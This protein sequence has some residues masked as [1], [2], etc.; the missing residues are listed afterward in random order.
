MYAFRPLLVFF[1]SVFPSVAATF[2]TVVAHPQ[3]LADLVIDEARKR[4]YVVNTASNQVEVYA[5]NTNPPRQTNVIKTDSVPLAIAMSRSGNLLYVACYSASS[6]DV[7]DL[8]SSTFASRSITLA[9][10]PEGLAVGFNEKV[11]ISTIGTG[12]GQDILITFD[13]TVAASQALG[14]VVIAP[15]APSAPTLPPP[16]GA[17]GLAS[18]ARLQASQ[19]GKTIIGVHEQANNTRTVFVFDVNSSTVL[20]SRNI[21]VISPVVA[22]SPDATRFLSGPTLLETSSL[23]VLGQQSATNAPFVFPTGATFNNQTSQGGAVFAQ[24]ILGQVLITGYNIVPVESP[25]AATNTS[26]LLFNNPNNMLIELGI[27]IPETLS[28]KMAITSDSAT[29]YALSQ[30]GFMVLP[31]GTLPQTPIA[32]P[33]S[34]VVLLANDQCGVTAAQNSA[35]IPVRNIGGKTLT[36]SVQVLTSASTSPTVRV[37]SR[38][39]GG[40][41]TAQF[42]AA[43]A[44]TIGTAAPDQLLIQSSEAVNI[45]PNVRVYQNNRNSEARGTIVPL[46]IGATTTGLTDM[47]ADSARQRLY[48]ANP[49]LNRIEIFDM[50]KQQFL[51]PITVGQ[52]PLSMAF[53][54]DGNTLYVANSGS[55]SISIVDLTEQAVVGRVSLPPIPM[56]AAFAILTPTVLASS[57]HGPQVIMS[58]GTPWKIVGNTLTP[59]TLN[60]N[61]VGS[62]RSIPAPQTMAGTPDG[63]YVL[64]LAGNGSAYLYDASVDDFV[65]TRSVIPTPIQGYYG[66][67]AAGLSGQYYLVNGQVLNAALTPI[68]SGA[69][70][71]GPTGGGG[72]PSPTGPTV[73]PRPV[74][75][76]AA[77]GTQSFAR[78]STPVRAS[79]SV[80]PSDAGLV[81]IVDASTERTI[82]SANALEGPLTA[83][84]GTARVNT[85]GRIMALDA[86]GAT[87]YV[88]TES[89]LSIIPISA[90]TP[91]A[92]QLTGSAVVNAANFTSPVAPIGLISIFGKNLAATAAASSTPLP[93]V[94]GGTCVTVNNAPIPLLATTAS[95]INAQLPPTLAAGTYPIVVRSIANQAASGSVN[96]TVSKYAPAIFFDSQGPVILHKDGTRVNKQHPATRDEELTI[97]ATGLGTTTGGRV[98]AG[99]PSPSSPLAV[100]AKV[101]L[102]FG[103]PTISNTAVIV[104]WSGLAPGMIGVYQINCR[105][106]GNHYNGNALPVTLRIGG[107]SSLTTGPTAAVV[108]VD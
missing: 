21:P 89:G 17:M 54:T 99:M 46:D 79:A 88:L 103:N 59:R 81:E 33:D 53:G 10:S 58:D 35:V 31:I 67:I 36:A 40:D 15:P 7:I 16:N 60:T 83:A 25:A 32:M 69:G 39:Y 96:V 8:T 107:V 38:S 91:A 48:I 105:I 43:A 97:Y 92:P 50:E 12:A 101:Q 100:T 68:G 28:G 71:T 102:W 45:V 13:P 56:N 11:L 98:T 24:T 30:S 52:L 84:V 66:P 29:I 75:A 80:A 23:L 63:S 9:A 95:Q 86:A 85:S 93:T 5:T 64:L 57:E 41:V 73:T 22:V 49:G 42:S 94:L 20:A 82:A 72:L 76:V 14:T 37:A 78:F 6:L 70:T 26:Q 65:S 62:A 4:L 19:D 34:N 18:H 106:P 2:G 55:E 87:A 77:A 90:A 27:Q 1:F 61:V 47:L 104:D 108:Y 74:S 44:R 51:T 3:P